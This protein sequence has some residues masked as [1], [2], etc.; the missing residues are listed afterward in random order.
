MPRT[1]RSWCITASGCNSRNIFVRC[2]GEKLRHKDL[3]EYSYFTWVRQ[4]S[5]AAPR[6]QDVDLALDLVVKVA[7]GLKAHTD[8]T[9]GL[10]IPMVIRTS[11]FA[12]AVAHAPLFRRKLS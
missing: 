7:S 11:R 5:H 1:N 3:A 12:F 10:I 9:S 6:G 4:L 8:E 2:R